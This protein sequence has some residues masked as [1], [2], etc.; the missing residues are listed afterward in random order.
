[1]S[2]QRNYNMFQNDGGG[3]SGFGNSSTNRQSGR[4]A[5]DTGDEKIAKMTS[6]IFN[7]KN[8]KTYQ[9]VF[10]IIFIIY[11]WLTEFSKV[12]PILKSLF[13]VALFALVAI[14]SVIIIFYV[15]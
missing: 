14:Q 7:P 9:I 6:T 4:V 5:T 13:L 3:G 2:Q 1:M 10:V 12:A 15:Q 8:M 11:I